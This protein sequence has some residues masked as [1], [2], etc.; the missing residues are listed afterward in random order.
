LA[1]NPKAIAATQARFSAATILAGKLALS[2]FFCGVFLH[3]S[4][5]II[6]HSSEAVRKSQNQLLHT[7]RSL[8]FFLKFTF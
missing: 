2:W 3:W 4:R 7:K 8:S 6:A 1:G 5:V